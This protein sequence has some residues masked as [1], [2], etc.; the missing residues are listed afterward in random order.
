MTIETQESG[1]LSPSAATPPPLA[2]MRG[3]ARHSLLI[4]VAKLVSE[5]GEFLCVVRDVSETGVR[6]KLFH[7][8]DCA[9]HLALEMANGDVYFIE[10][11]W[12]TDGQAGF[13]F[14][15]PIDVQAFIAEDSRHPRRPVRLNLKKQGWLRCNGKSIPAELA[16]ITQE[17]AGLVCEE[18]VAVGQQVSFTVAGLPVLS[19]TIRWRSSPAYGMAFLNYFSLDELARLTAAMQL[20]A[21]DKQIEA[22]QA[23]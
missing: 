4:R 19:G 1:T 5:A 17:G 15:A 2:E 9:S 8:L 12:E 7:P 18:F 21:I 3:A 6:L 16:N 14:A 22:A 23:S 11:V 13:R 10:K 20:G